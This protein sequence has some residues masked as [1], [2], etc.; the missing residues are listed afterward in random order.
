[1]KFYV[2]IKI[3]ILNRAVYLC[4]FNGFQ[5]NQPYCGSND[6]NS[7]G[8]SLSEILFSFMLKKSILSAMHHQLHDCLLNRLFRRRS[9][10]T[11]KLRVI[12]LCAGN[13]PVTSE[14]P[15]QMASNE[16]SFFI[17]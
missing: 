11:S 9:N 2:H 1:M 13:S 17:W 14:F 5:T 15:A 3:K 4:E 10:K 16:E 6:N 7:T 8:V 12:G